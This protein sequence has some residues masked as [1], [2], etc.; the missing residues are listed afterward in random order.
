MSEEEDVEQNQEKENSEQNEDNQS[1][2]EDQN[3]EEEKVKEET[4]E[5]EENEEK[6]EK[7]EKEEVEEP[8]EVREEPQ[9][10]REEPQETREEPEREEHEAEEA[11]IHEEADNEQEI[12]TEIIIFS[13]LSKE[14]KI[15]YFNFFIANDTIFNREPEGTWIAEI[16]IFEDDKNESPDLELSS[17]KK[18]I[19]DLRQSR[20]KTTKKDYDAIY[21][22]LI[23]VI[24]PAPGIKGTK[25][26]LSAIKYMIQEIYSLKFLKDTQALFNKEDVEPEPFPVFVGNFLINK[27]PKKDTLH[28][29]AI[30]FMLSL[31]FYG[32]KH[33]DIKVFQ[34]FVTE[35]YDAD[36]LIFYLFVRSCIEKEQKV[37]F[38][39]KAKENLGQGLLYG[40]ENDDILIPVKKCEKLAKAIFGTD[41]DELMT[42]FMDNIKKLLETDAADEKK[43]HLKANAILNMSLANYHDSRGKVDEVDEDKEKDN[44]DE[45]KEKKKHKKDKDKKEKKHKKDKDKKDKDKKDKKDKKHEHKHKH[46]KEAE[47]EE[48]KE[49]EEKD[50][51][52]EDEKDNNE[53]EVEIEEKKPEKATP[54]KPT[55]LRAAAPKKANLKTSSA[56]SNTKISNTNSSI[57]SKPSTTSTETKS[58]K[59]TKASNTI[60]VPATKS[61]GTKANPNKININK[62][63]SSRINTTSGF[64]T[65]PST[66]V[67]KPVRKVSQEARVDPN[68][69]SKTKI[70]K[71]Q[72]SS[73]VGKRKVNTSVG[74]RTAG[75]GT[76]KPVEQTLEFK[77]ILNK[78]RIEKANNEAE[79]LT[80]LLYIIS[81][82]FK[83]KEIDGFFKN[84]VDS[85]PIF[86][87][88]SAKIFANIK[89]TKEF[90]LKK[91]NGICKYIAA[92]DKNGFVNFMKIRDKGGKHSFESMKSSFNSLLKSG[93]LKNLNENN[94]GEFCKMILE[95]PE[96][97]VQTSKSLLKYCE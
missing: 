63:T 37:F 34:Q 87:N 23:K 38:L 60:K 56:P 30:D 21:S 94:I 18:D 80:C 4:V 12:P 44:S 27:F 89:N 53:E 88:Y 84:I 10:T 62:S 19:K 9:E 85:N 76:D 68:K 79:K 59:T 47:S 52:E 69:E 11:D 42:T 20:F 54:A 41:E 16:D 33:K 25:M 49:E 86:K 67:N 81:D 57:K 31:D 83:L 40:Q 29:K 24:N 7:D 71:K 22:K 14:E 5:K 90:T 2:Q 36:D 70:A 8:Q 91:L 15:K 73:S 78:N 65:K 92:G 39:E 95:I 96:L 93:P 61:T 75:H 3:S 97:S 26:N 28:K 50:D 72:G 13:T 64:G 66:A 82:Y 48:E 77:K 35:E 17:K 74:K 43:K 51:K 58:S 32:L 1:N 6:E 55:K 46:K 45:E